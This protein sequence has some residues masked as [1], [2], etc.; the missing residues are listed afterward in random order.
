M[1][2][3]EYELELKILLDIPLSLVEEPKFLF[4]VNCFAEWN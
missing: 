4:W 3:L 1:T 2:G